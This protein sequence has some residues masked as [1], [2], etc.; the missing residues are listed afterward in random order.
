[1]LEKFVW[2][3]F[4]SDII[5]RTLTKYESD[6]VGVQ[7]VRWEGGSTEPAGEYRMLV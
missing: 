7:E 2:G 6:S 1:M 3:R 5:K 4:T